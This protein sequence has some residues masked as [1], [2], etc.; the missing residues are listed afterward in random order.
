MEYKNYVFDE[1]NKDMLLELA[2]ND[3]INGFTYGYFPTNELTNAVLRD[4]SALD[5]GEVVPLGLPNSD[6]NGVNENQSLIVYD[7]SDDSP[8]MQS[9]Y[10]VLFDDDTDTE[11]SI[12]EFKEVNSILEIESLKR[13]VMN[14]AD[15]DVLP[16]I[17]CCSRENSSI[18][19]E[20]LD[21]MVDAY[22]INIFK[23][24]TLRTIGSNLCIHNPKDRSEFVTLSEFSESL[25]KDEPTY[26]NWYILTDS[27]ILV[28]ASINK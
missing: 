28:S 25:L 23:E 2:Q 1:L 13:I 14:L 18:F 10:S 21:V 22:M 9:I 4:E 16:V 3:V 11:L 5:L 15:V 19:F 7:T 6:D 26:K 24:S 17:L 8:I 20:P 12:K 27:G